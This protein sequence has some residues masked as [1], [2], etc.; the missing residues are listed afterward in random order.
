MSIAI[1][2]FICLFLGALIGFLA[3]LLGIGGGILLVPVLSMLLPQL[4]LAE[5]GPAFVIA[6]A[7]SLASIIF[8][9]FS[10]TLTHHRLNNIDWSLAMWVTVSVALGA[11]LSSFF[12]GWFSTQ[13]LKNV[14]AVTMAFVALRMVFSA[15]VTPHIDAPAPNKLIIVPVC[16]VIGGLASLIG[17][18]GGALIVPLLNQLGVDVKKA[19]GIAAVGSA[20]IAVVAAVGYG[21]SGWDYFALEDGFLGYIYLPALA[22]VIITSSVSAPYGA[23]MVHRLPVKTLKRVFAGVLSVV[24]IKMVMS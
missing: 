12:S 11:G 23:K 7:T 14:F 16:T 2:F 6:V 22:G 19:I 1:I 5:S 4:G 9:A 13:L 20:C 10:S 18:G 3:G 24:V 15:S 21:F 8:T 17:I